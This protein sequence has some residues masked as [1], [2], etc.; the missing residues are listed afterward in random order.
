MRKFVGFLQRIVRKF[1]KF[2]QR[3]VKKFVEFLQ[4]LLCIL[5]KMC[6]FAAI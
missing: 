6:N 1:V 3:I 5:L 2:L 4:E